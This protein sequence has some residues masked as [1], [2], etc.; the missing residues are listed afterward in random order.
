MQLAL[1]DEIGPYRLVRKLGEGTTSR[2]FEV[3]HVRIG[4]RAAMKV[5]HADAALPGVGRRLFAEARAVNLINH[6][7][8]VEITD[9][10]EPTQENPTHALV[11]ELLDGRGLADVIAVEGAL[12]P[13]RLVPIM[14]QVCDGLAAVHAAGFVHRDLKPENVFLVERDGN[15]DFVKLLDFGLV[16]AMRP[17]VGSPT[18]TREG[19]FM[20][21]PAYASPEQAEGKKVDQRTDIYAVGIMVY[22]LVMGR[23]PFEADGIG[24]LLMKQITAA[25]PRLPGELLANEVGRALDAIIQACLTKDPAQRV[26]TARQLAGMFRQL[27]AGQRVAVKTIR[28]AMAR[29][30]LTRRRSALAVVPALALGA[31]VLLIGNYARAPRRPPPV[32]TSTTAAAA[33]APLASATQATLTASSPSAAGEPRPKPLPASRRWTRAGA[34]SLSKATTLDP[35]R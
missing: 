18:A 20:G 10:V 29:Q 33:P 35:Y 26:L 11:M 27:A 7:N 15:A 32:A 12:S 14:A 8:V 25:A 28:R 9:I 21:S 30:P 23:L 2:V 4:R 6:P 16:K 34:P 31:M 5:A 3:E 24:E 1:G 13:A 19:T 17:D 22:E